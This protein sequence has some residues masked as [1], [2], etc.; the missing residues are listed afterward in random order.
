MTRNPANQPPILFCGFV[1]LD[2]EVVGGTPP[3]PGRCPG[4]CDG[5]LSALVSGKFFYVWIHKKVI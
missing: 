5:A 4:L 1:W 2:A 3:N